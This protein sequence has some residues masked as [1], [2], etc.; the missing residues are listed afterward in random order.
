YGQ[1]VV[2]T[3]SLGWY[4]RSA[5]P[6][7]VE[8]VL[9]HLTRFLPWGFFLLPAVWWWVR[10]RDPDR[11]RLLVWAGTLI[12]L[13]SLSGEQRARYFLPLWP[14]LSVLVAEFCVRG[15]ERARGLL[16]SPAAI[17]LLLMIGAGAFVIWG[18]VPPAAVV[19]L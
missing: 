5:V 1:A 10:P 19:F 16:D 7:R 13:L 2:M 18:S 11:T 12:V 4:F 6:Y 9:A 3:D 14:V 8:A 17:Y 15:A